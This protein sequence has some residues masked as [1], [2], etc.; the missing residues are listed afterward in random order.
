M[1]TKN[2]KKIMRLIST[3]KQLIAGLVIGALVMLPTG[4]YLS[5]RASNNQRTEAPKTTSEVPSNTEKTAK[6]TTQ[7]PAPT[8]SSTPTQ[9]TPQPKA[10]A[11][12]SK[13]TLCA[14]HNSA[15]QALLPTFEN[16]SYNQYQ[17]WK[18]YYQKDTSRTEAEKTAEI[19][20]AYNDYVNSLN[21][22]K[23][24]AEDFV[25]KEGCTPTITAVSA[26]AK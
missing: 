23:A 8:A 10:Q 16:S 2:M 12:V 15:Q 5:E 7:Q 17:T 1:G 21:T 24:R 11:T 3:N 6:E 19:T 25:R 18:Q 4:L 20:R 26:R 9:A 14:N 13:A 22:D